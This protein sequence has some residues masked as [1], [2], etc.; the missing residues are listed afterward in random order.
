MKGGYPAPVMADFAALAKEV[1]FS[2]CNSQSTIL[3][4]ITTPDVYHALAA[5]SFRRLVWPGSSRHTE[6]QGMANRC[7]RIHEE[8]IR[9]RDHYVN[10]ELYV[11][12]KWRLL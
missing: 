3:A 7:E 10:S 1:I 8:L 2:R 9:L 5:K 4:S 6:G 11:D 12:R